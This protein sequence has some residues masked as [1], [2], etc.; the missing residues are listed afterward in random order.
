MRVL[1]LIGARGGSKGVHRKNL[2]SLGGT[3]LV[4]WAIDA[5]LAARTVDRVVVTTD[6]AEIVEVARA[7]GADVPF[8]RPA[9]LATDTSLQIDAIVHAVRTLEEQGD[10][11]D[12]V[13]L[14][15][16]TVPL[17]S[18]AD[19][20]ATVE[21]L[22]T[23]D[24]DSAI[25][26]AEVDAYHP[27]TYYMKDEHDVLTPLLDSDPAGVLRQ[28]FPRCY[29]RTGAVYATRCSVVLDERSLYGQR[30]VGHV[31]PL[32]RSFNIDTEFDWD[33]VEAWLEA[34]ASREGRS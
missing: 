31:M 6:D 8:L 25:T 16:P 21:L 33:L 1:G 29:W 19:I 30:T 2:R 5:G 11:Y 34:R 32:E 20:D 26:V 27:L 28:D 9:A 13:A 17:R 22:E 7:H 18:A 4:G 15:Q 24:A 12:A 14:L 10:A 23:S 3:P